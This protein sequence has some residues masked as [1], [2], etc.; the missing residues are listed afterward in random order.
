MRLEKL[1][2]GDSKNVTVD[3][4][5]NKNKNDVRPETLV[6]DNSGEV[7]VIDTDIY[8]HIYIKKVLGTSI[9]KIMIFPI[10]KDNAINFVS[11]YYRP[12]SVYVVI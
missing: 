5:T 1:S 7:S 8:T 4:K 12:Y 3:S 10:L 2:T 6:A 9:F 11:N